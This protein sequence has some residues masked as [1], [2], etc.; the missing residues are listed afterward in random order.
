MVALAHRLDSYRSEFLD[1]AAGKE[2]RDLK[3]KVLYRGQ[4]VVFE[5]IGESKEDTWRDLR[6]VGASAVSFVPQRYISYVLG[7]PVMVPRESASNLHY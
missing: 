5:Q 3:G 7:R 6:L 4:G 1:A 2:Q